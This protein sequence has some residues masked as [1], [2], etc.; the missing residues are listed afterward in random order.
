MKPLGIGHDY[1]HCF[2]NY[3]CKVKEKC[4]R[5]LLHLEVKENAAREDAPNGA[6]FS[7]HTYIAPNR[8]GEV[9]EYYWEYKEEEK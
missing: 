3:G 6:G 2:G 7:L 4:V 9:C 5:Y 1:A 8:R